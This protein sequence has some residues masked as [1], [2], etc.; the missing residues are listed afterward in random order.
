MNRRKLI[1]LVILSLLGVV[2][3]SMFATSL[4]APKMDTSYKEDLNERANVKTESLEVLENIKTSD[5]E[6]PDK[7][8]TFTVGGPPL[9]FDLYL[10]GDYI[11]YIYIELVTEHN[12]TE[13]V[14]EVEDHD[15]DYFCIFRSEMYFSPDVGRSFEV[16][17]GTSDSG[18]HSIKFTASTRVNFNLYISISQGPKCLYDRMSQAEIDAL[19]F[20]Y[21]RKFN[22]RVGWQTEHSLELDTDWMYRFKIGRVTAIDQASIP[23]VYV[24][25]TL[26]D[27]EGLPFMIWSNKLIPTIYDVVSFV[28]GTSQGGTYTIK[29]SVSCSVPNVN[30]AYTCSD[31]YQISDIEN[32]N[33][34]KYTPPPEEDEEDNNLLGDDLTSN[35][36]FEISI[37][38]IAFIGIV[39]V[40]LLAIFANHRKKNAIENKF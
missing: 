34:T 33:E 22:N 8:Y 20:Y 36:P 10:K 5:V 13:M 40:V 38:A 26:E 31:D 15:D 17:F 11:F 23:F 24:T 21:V 37:G 2:L 1:S 4:N 39:T 16:P 3:M 18:P 32:V 35:L 14:I 25:Y 30:I 7:V 29:I 6:L 27:P 12:V 28:F 9:Q 19:N